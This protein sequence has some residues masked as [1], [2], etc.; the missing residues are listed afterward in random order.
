M[1]HL[2]MHHLSWTTMLDLTKHITV[3]P[4]LYTAL[5]TLKRAWHGWIV[6]LK[7]FPVCQIRWG[8]VSEAIVS[9]LVEHLSD[10]Q[11]SPT[12]AI[13]TPVSREC[14]SETR[15][16]RN[17]TSQTS[18]R[19]TE[20]W[21]I[22]LEENV[23]IRQAGA[24]RF[25]DLRYPSRGSTGGGQRPRIIYEQI[26]QVWRSLGLW[27]GF[28]VRMCVRERFPR[29]FCCLR[30]SDQSDHEPCQNRYWCGPYLKCLPEA[31]RQPLSSTF[32]LG[33]ISWHVRTRSREKWRRSFNNWQVI[34]SC[35]LGSQSGSNYFAVFSLSGLCLSTHLDV[36]SRPKTKNCPESRRGR[37]QHRLGYGLWLHILIIP[38]LP[39]VRAPS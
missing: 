39:T 12:R 2:R 14:C 26:C 19:G 6:W 29:N 10:S 8:V 33:F 17:G 27:K 18:D 9:A 28:L 35:T 4:S 22:Q 23:Q 24:S 30:R 37:Y 5:V 21:Q 3:V 7:S 20:D 1:Q 36:L 25:C 38:V 32:V 15:T 16:T 11:I 34:L 13:L 31:H